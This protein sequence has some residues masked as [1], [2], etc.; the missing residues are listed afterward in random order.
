MSLRAASVGP[1]LLAGGLVL[2]AGG[3]CSDPEATAVVYA[4]P[5]LSAETLSWVE[6]A[7]HQTHPE[8]WVRFETLPDD[9]VLTRLRDAPLDADVWLG[10]PSWRLAGAAR[11]GL[12]AGW[13]EVLA[14]PVVLAFNTDS[15][16]RSRAPRDWIDLLHPR[17]SGELIIPEP[18]LVDGLTAVLLQHMWEAHARYGDADEGLDW[19]VRMDAWRA[20]YPGDVGEAV[21]SL[22][23]GHG[24][25]ALLPLSAAETCAAEGSCAFRVPETATPV[26]IRGV[27]RVAS[28]PHDGAAR[29]FLDWLGTEE[30]IEGLVRLTGALPAGDLKRLDGLVL[31]SIPADSVAPV[32]DE[33][34]ERWRDNVRGRAT[35]IF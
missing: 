6:D 24:T 17:W 12:V 15:I 16:S 20:S 32:A 26:L 9:E 8:T 4:S 35:Q 30:A 1:A 7:F 2:L 23:L 13:S 22:R 11:E 3:A 25:L 14:D 10:A 5:A 29:A 21:R 33:W 31:D 34:V 19:F 18:G 27:G 28:S